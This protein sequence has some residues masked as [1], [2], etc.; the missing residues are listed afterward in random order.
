MKNLLFIIFAVCSMQQERRIT[1]HFLNEKKELI[2]VF[3]YW[4]DYNKMPTKQEN[5]SLM[6]TIQGISPKIVVT[7]PLVQ[8]Y[9]IQGEEL[10]TITFSPNESGPVYFVI[11]TAKSESKVNSGS[12]TKNSK[13][14]QKRTIQ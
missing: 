8:V 5:V 11:P 3:A 10:M 12:K 13:G 6:R 4:N 9:I 14:T 2:P 7:K 1:L